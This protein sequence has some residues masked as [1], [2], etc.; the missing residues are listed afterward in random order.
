MGLK[1]H[2]LKVAALGGVR[3]PNKSVKGF[4]CVSFDRPKEAPLSLSV[5]PSRVEL[6]ADCRRP[7]VASG[8]TVRYIPNC[9]RELRNIIG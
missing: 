8:V 9:I 6:G 1:L 4:S 7:G 5:P 3:Y 2:V